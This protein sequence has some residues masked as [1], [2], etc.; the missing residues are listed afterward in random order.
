ML[1]L[2]RFL[3]PG[4]RTILGPIFPDIESAPQ[5]GMVSSYASLVNPYEGTTLDFMQAPVINGSTYAKIEKED[6]LP[7]IDC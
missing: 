4:N 7:K 1:K 6:V 3:P 5:R 2:S